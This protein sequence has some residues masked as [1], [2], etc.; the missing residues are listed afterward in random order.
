MKLQGFNKNINPVK[1]LL[2]QINCQNLFSQALQR[3]SLIRISIQWNLYE[4]A[5][6]DKHIF[7]L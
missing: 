7:N 6:K 1:L 2:D 4:Y 5:Q 3:L